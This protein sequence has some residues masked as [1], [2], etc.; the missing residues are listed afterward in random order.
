MEADLPEDLSEM[1]P[2]FDDFFPGCGSLF[3]DPNSSQ[4]DLG[5]DFNRRDNI[6]YDYFQRNNA[7][8][9]LEEILRLLRNALLHQHFPFKYPFHRD[10]SHSSRVGK[11]SF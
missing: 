9:L 10:L 3:N 1:F 6:S 5:I 11:L 2:P 7:E 4:Q 8:I